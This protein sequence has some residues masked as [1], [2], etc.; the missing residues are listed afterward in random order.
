M[1]QNNGH[2]KRTEKGL[3]TPDNCAVAEIARI[4]VES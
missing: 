1:S 4:V 2:V 3:L